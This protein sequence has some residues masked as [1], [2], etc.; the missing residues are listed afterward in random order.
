MKRKIL[1][2]DDEEFGRKITENM[3]EE[4]GFRVESVE[5][6]EQ[7]WVRLREGY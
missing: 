1:L 6:G 7:A 2:A 5:D 3:L 4:L